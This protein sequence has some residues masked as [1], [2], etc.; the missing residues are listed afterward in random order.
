VSHHPIAFLR[1]LAAT[2]AAESVP[3]AD[4]LA[5]FIH[6]GDEAAFAILVA[7]HGPMVLGVC[8]HILGDRHSA[9]DC[10]QAAFLVLARRAA[11]LRRPQALAAW[12]H[13]VALRVAWRAR[14]EARR[15]PLQAPA[16]APV[17]ADPHPDPLDALTARELLAL[18]D[19]EIAHLPEAYRLAVLLCGREG[20]TVEEA[21][22]LL[23]W[24][25][26]SVR[27]RLVRGRRRL[28][29]R[30]VRRGLSLA[31][32]AA[33]VEVPRGAAGMPAALVG[34]TARAA[35]A[36]AAG[37]E[38]A[39]VSARVMVLAQ[40]G[41]RGLVPGKGWFAAALLLAA[42]VVLA[43][44]A[45][46]ARE[47][48]PGSGQ[49]A[50]R[51]QPA[52]VTSARTDPYGDLLPSRALTRLGTVRFRHSENVLDIAFAPDGKT[53]AAADSDLVC[54]WDAATG[55][56]LR[57]LQQATTGHGLAFAPDGKTLATADFTA[58]LLWDPATGRQ[59]RRFPLQGQPVVVSLLFSPDGKTLAWLTQ[60]NTLRLSDAA[61]GKVLHR[62]PGPP[63]VV[64]SSVTF[65]PDSRTLA[66]ACQKDNEIPLYDTATGAE[67]RRLVGH[68]ESVYTVAFSPDGKTVASSARDDTLR[69]WDAATGKQLR[70]VKHDGGVW[71]LA[72]SPDGTVLATGGWNARLWDAAT[73]KLLRACERD[74]DGHVE[75]LAFS[76]DGKTV[77]ASRSNSHAPSLWDVASGKRRLA[78]AGHL[79]PVAGIAVSPDGT[80]VA[81]AAWEKN[82][83][84]RNAV[85]LWDPTTGKELGTAGTD[86]GFVGGLAFSP[87]GR[88]LAAGNEDGTIRLWDPA[89]RREVRRLTGHKDMVE[90]VGFTA[91]GKVL[92]SLGYHD[93]TIRL[94]DVAAGK[95]LRH[96]RDNQ[97]I[98]S[99]G[100]ALAPDG[101][102]I[103]QG[104][105]APPSLVLWDAATGKAVDRFGGY[106]RPI[107]A[108]ALSP[109][110]RTLATAVR[111]DGVRQWD[112]ATGKEVRRLADASVWIGLLVFS[113]DGRTLAQGGGAVRLWE[114]ATGTEQC[115]F[116]G[117]RGPVRSGAFSPDGRK[118]F[119]G[120]EDTTVLIWDVTGRVAEGR[121]EAVHYSPRELDD[122]WAD[123]SVADASRAHRALWALVAAPEQAVRMLRDRLRPVV[124]AD[125]ERVARLLPELDSEDFAR[126]DKATKELHQMGEAVLPALRKALAGRPAQELRRRAERLV[127]ELG[128][129]SPEQ[130]AAV[131]AVEALERV[132]SPDARQVLEA[133]AAGVPE[134]RRTREAR[135]ALRR[136]ADRPVPA[137]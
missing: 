76:P 28:H 9:E 60:D 34:A 2:P 101:K 65:S 110:G 102:T 7:R 38:T 63:N 47:G 120:G 43:G 70:R 39:G 51:A 128:G 80:L 48:R 98:P 4:L 49:E 130:L 72:F 108:L 123:L 117:H 17:A 90:W 50:D 127:D 122:L 131:R 56:E 103:V 132:G 21:A 105:E 91:D 44:A 74:D 29:A 94:W 1:W 58:I 100:I 99:G 88:L 10:T 82:Y 121:P 104:G 35:L 26:G 107:T 136:L 69:F 23:G 71:K 33:A 134:A 78:F 114:L 45:M 31:A 116:A 61:T 24:T 87:D 135:A 109:D 95:E 32:V 18:V 46:L 115:R 79:G 111:G 93:R 96:F 30:L 20:R 112:V 41:L 37:G 22:R 53:L 13:G 5:R 57:R 119:S 15:Q 27:G 97:A 118:F 137:R 124:A 133:L 14:A 40:A 129:L 8:T 55:K 68:R 42:G 106:A 84:R 16:G 54:L 66:L 36:F 6:H 86:L 3:D 81:T 59:L 113:P 85:R 67:V 19:E 64:S 83:R 11:S 25:P 125:P 75:C 77:A 52:R 62:W 92:A 126:R 89:T 73:G 12:L